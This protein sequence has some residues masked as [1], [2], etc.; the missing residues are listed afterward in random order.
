MKHWI[1]E[2]GFIIVTIGIFIVLLSFTLYTL[3]SIT[4]AQVARSIGN[5][6]GDVKEGMDE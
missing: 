5:F 2:Y 4:S 3:Q 6:I 1:K